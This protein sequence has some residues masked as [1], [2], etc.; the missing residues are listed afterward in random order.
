ML[1][2]GLLLLMACNGGL[3]AF[4]G[5]SVCLTSPDGSEDGRGWLP[6]LSWL[7]HGSYLSLMARTCSDAPLMARTLCLPLISDALRA[8]HSPLAMVCLPL[9]MVATQR[10]DILQ[11]SVG[12]A[13]RCSLTAISMTQN[14][15]TFSPPT[16]SYAF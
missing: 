8:C 3:Q 9:M 5:L 11:M 2:D 4:L 12:D 1:S 7:P 6:S 14:F 15:P 16:Y 10:G 13:Y